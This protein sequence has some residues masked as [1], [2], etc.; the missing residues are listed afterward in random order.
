MLNWFINIKHFYQGQNKQYN[1]APFGWNIH[2]QDQNYPHC[3]I[4]FG[5]LQTIV[6]F[7]CTAHLWRYRRV[8]ME[9]I[10]LLMWMNNLASTSWLEHC[11]LIASWTLIEIVICWI[12]KRFLCRHS[13]SSADFPLLTSLFDR[14]RVF[15]SLSLSLRVYVH[16]CDKACV[17]ACVADSWEVWILHIK[18]T[19]AP[20]HTINL[21]PLPQVCCKNTLWYAHLSDL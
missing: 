2:L 14:I 6:I 16:G 15:V 7:P 8:A 18:R 19:P 3:C 9:W 11:Y 17:A 20:V 10:N 4:H 5:P 12:E 13:A 21:L 1:W